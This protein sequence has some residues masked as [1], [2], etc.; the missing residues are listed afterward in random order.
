MNAK[1]EINFLIN[2]QPELKGSIHTIIDIGFNGHKYSDYD[3]LFILNNEVDYRK[4]YH[5]LINKTPTKFWD[6][7][8]IPKN[9]FLTDPSICFGNLLQ[10]QHLGYQHQNRIIYGEKIQPPKFESDYIKA[11]HLI[12]GI[13]R[14]QQFKNNTKSTTLQYTHQRAKNL[15]STYLTIYAIQ[16]KISA[17]SKQAILS[18]YKEDDHFQLPRHSIDIIYNKMRCLKPKETSPI[19]NIYKNQI[20]PIF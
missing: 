5:F 9:L 13:P 2:S 11:F 19:Y 1:K 10:L 7:S 6:L 8:F 16:N 3:L 12:R 17:C 20:N 15:L 18:K 14:L 4:I